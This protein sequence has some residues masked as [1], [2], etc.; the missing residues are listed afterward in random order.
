MSL[1]P[2]QHDALAAYARTGDRREAARSLAMPFHTFNDHLREVFVKANATGAVEALYRLGW[3]RIPAR[4]VESCGE[5]PEVL[6][7][8]AGAT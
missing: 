8:R 3:L 1:S 6:A 4:P 5:C 7:I 2:R